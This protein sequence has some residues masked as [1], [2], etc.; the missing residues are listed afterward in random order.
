[1]TEDKT[2]FSQKYTPEEQITRIATML[3]ASYKQDAGWFIV[4]EIEKNSKLL[5][6]LIIVCCIIA[7]I[8]LAIVNKLY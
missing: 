2:S 1:M 8:L 3:E 4:D 6:I 5:K 7:F